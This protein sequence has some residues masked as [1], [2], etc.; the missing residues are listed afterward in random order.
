MFGI[1]LAVIWFYVILRW[2][3]FTDYKRQ[4]IQHTKEA[5]KR[6]IFLIPSFLCLLLPVHHMLWLQIALKGIVSAGLIGSIWWEF[7]DGWLNLKRGYKWRF[8]G[9]DDP[10]D[11]KTDHFL[12]RLTPLQQGLLKWGLISSF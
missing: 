7:F 9:S 1:A 4:H 12:Q 11:A 10:D 2:D 6:S 5:V 8:N 3:V